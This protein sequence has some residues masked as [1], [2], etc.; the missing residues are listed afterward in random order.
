MSAHTDWRMWWLAARPKTLT[1]AVVPVFVGSALA[2]S[3]QGDMAWLPLSGALPAAIL[4]QVATNLINDACDF[5]RG[6]DTKERVGPKRVTQAGIFTPQAVHAGGLL[7]FALALLCCV[8]AFILRGVP[9]LVLVVTCCFAGYLY[10]GGPYPLGYLGLGD[11][12]V[13]AFFG[14]AATGGVRMIHGG[15]TFLSPATLVASLQARLPHETPSHTLACLTNRPP[16]R[17][18]LRHAV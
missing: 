1:A 7:C 6:A 5:Q 17:D 12:T 11:V 10:T 18:R 3:G 14:I 15:G 4:I 8:P 13:V 9:L 2:R 16:E